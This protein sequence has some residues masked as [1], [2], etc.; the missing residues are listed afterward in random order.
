[1]YLGFDKKYEAVFNIDNNKK[2][3][4]SSILY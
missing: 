4:L 3:L 1:M 2:C